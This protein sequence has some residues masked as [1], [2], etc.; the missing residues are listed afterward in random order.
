MKSTIRLYGNYD[1]G[2]HR[3]FI[4]MRSDLAEYRIQTVMCIIGWSYK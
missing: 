1:F 2:I 4:C 3:I